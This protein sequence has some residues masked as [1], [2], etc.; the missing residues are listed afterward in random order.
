MS[1]VI[2]K[3]GF[4]VRIPQIPSRY[5]ANCSKDFGVFVHGDTKGMNISKAE[6]AGLTKGEFVEMA[7]VCLEQKILTFEP[8]YLNE[9]FTEIWGIPTAGEM[10]N[11]FPENASELSTFLIHRQ[12]QDKLAQLV[13]KFSKEAFTEWVNSGMKGDY[14]KFAIEK[15]T[16]YYFSN[17]FRF[18]LTQIEGKH[19]IYYY[20]KSSFR[21]A[22]N[23]I[24]KKAC[25]L[26][27]E[28]YQGHLDGM[29]YCTDERLVLNHQ[30]CT[31]LLAE[32]KEDKINVET[33]TNGKK[34]ILASSK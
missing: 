10:K 28:I 17:I 30:Q 9:T 5:R 34:K 12:S 3:D 13:E 25:D 29:N 21:K 24:E 33:N 1:H 19:G 4:A 23:D 20:V 15:A 16:E 11:Q 22:E 7:L 8:N 26:A 2:V 27:K 31:K 6:K 14:Q 32:S 18:E